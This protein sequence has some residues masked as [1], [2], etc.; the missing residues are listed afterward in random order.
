MRKLLLVILSTLTIFGY[1]S[2]AKDA[3][4]AP[5]CTNKDPVKD[6][7]TLIH[8]ASQYLALS[9]DSLSRDSIGLF[10]H[11]V[12]SGNATKPNVNS[13]MSVTYVAKLM[14]NQT[15]DSATN[16]NLGGGYLYQLIPGWQL[17]LPQIGAGG[18]IQLFIPSALAWGC[19][20]ISSVPPD[21]CVYFDVSLLTVN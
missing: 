21:S 18:R 5:A 11:I 17:G 4:S 12:D 8:F 13:L 2:C 20:G 6:S 15:F 10:W 7:N 19:N 9:R 3:P 1:I 14:N 16:T